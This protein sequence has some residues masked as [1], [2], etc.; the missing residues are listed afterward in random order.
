MNSSTACSVARSRPN[1]LVVYH[2]F[3]KDQTYIHNLAHFLLFGYSEDCDYLVVIAG[4]HAIDLP[5]RRNIRYLFTENSNSDFGGYCAAINSPLAN[6]LDYEFVYF[7]NSSVRGP[8]LPPY[9]GHDWKS[10]FSAKLNG[11]IGLV[12]ST[13]NILSRESPYSQHYKADCGGC[14]PFSH[15]QTMAYAMPNKSLAYLRDAGFYSNGAKLT[16]TQVIL[17]YELHLSQL[18][19]KRGWNIAAILPEYN[20]IDFRKSHDD[21]NTVAARELHGDPNWKHG[22]FGRSA[23]PFEVVFVKTNREIFSEGYLDRLAYSAFCQR[24]AAA[25]WADCAFVTRYIESISRVARSCN[26]VSV[27]YPSMTLDEIL[28][29]TEALLQQDPT[30]R[31]QVEEILSRYQSA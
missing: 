27:D 1:S 2:F 16:K 17:R 19:L 28:K 8:F 26:H 10:V 22:Y 29:W 9:A 7:V 18:I 5:E 21:P 12:G 24:D 3:E 25:D 23:H 15:V 6:V 4:Q 13:I 11:D 31:V 20:R 30:A 14:E